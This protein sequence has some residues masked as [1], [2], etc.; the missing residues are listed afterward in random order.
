MN[1]TEHIHSRNNFPPD[2]L[3]K[4][5]GQH[6]AWSLDGKRILAGD[7]DLL[8]LVARLDQAGFREDEYVLSFPSADCEISGPVAVVTGVAPCLVS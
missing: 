7:A 3:L 2:E 8:N 6:I 1:W 5:E 4:Y